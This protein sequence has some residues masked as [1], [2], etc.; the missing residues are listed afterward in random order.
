MPPGSVRIDEERTN[1]KGIEVSGVVY[2]TL[3][4]FTEGEECP[5]GSYT[6]VVPFSYLIEVTGNK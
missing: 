1:E 2:V 4:Y 6:G 5:A 3:M